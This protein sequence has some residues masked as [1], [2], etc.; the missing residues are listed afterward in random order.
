M[1]T[2]PLAGFALAYPAGWKILRDVQATDVVLL[3][4]KTQGTAFQ[5]NI[6]I[7]HT[8]ALADKKALNADAVLDAVRQ[9][10]A[11][12]E[13]LEQKTQSLQGEEALRLVYLTTLQS[14]RL[15]IVSYI[16]P[17][18]NTYIITCTT[19]PE[20]LAALRTTCDRVAASFHAVRP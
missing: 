15:A 3:P 14:T 19:V 9:A 16:I 10:G 7:S 8:S 20:R 5:D 17:L 6:N 2:D 13:L 18:A 1:Y 12:V 4:P 11:K